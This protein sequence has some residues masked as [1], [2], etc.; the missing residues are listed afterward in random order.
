MKWV[1]LMTAGEQSV[2][3]NVAL[4]SLLSWGKKFLVECTNIFELKFFA[5]GHS[6]CAF[7]CPSAWLKTVESDLQKC[8]VLTAAPV[9]IGSCTWNTLNSITSLVLRNSRPPRYVRLGAKLIDAF[10]LKVPTCPSSSFNTGGGNICPAY[11]DMQKKE[12]K[13]V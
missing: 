3:L 6:L 10:H 9:V 8:Q 7:C 4:P 2:P 5:S 11:K 12:K 13:E 1:P